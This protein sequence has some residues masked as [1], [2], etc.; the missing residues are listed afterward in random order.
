MKIEE[1]SQV[2]SLTLDI[3]EISGISSVTAGAFDV[4]QLSPKA[5]PLQL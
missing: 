3:I 2:F 1:K 4:R 5:A